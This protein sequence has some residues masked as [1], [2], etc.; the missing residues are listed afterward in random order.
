MDNVQRS[1]ATGAVLGVPTGAISAYDA[2]RNDRNK[3]SNESEQT[4]QNQ[5][6]DIV[7]NTVD[8]GDVDTNDGQSSTTFDEKALETVL[9]DID[10]EGLRDEYFN[11]LR[12]DINDGLITERAKENTAY[13]RLAQSYLNATNQQPSESELSSEQVDKFKAAELRDRMDQWKSDGKATDINDLLGGNPMTFVDEQAKLDFAN[14]AAFSQ[15]QELAKRN[16]IDPL[17]GNAIREWLSDIGNV[18]VTVTPETDE[19]SHPEITQPT[20]VQKGATTQIQLGSQGTQNAD[21]ELIEANEL[22]VNLKP[23]LYQNRDR[24]SADSQM[25][26]N[27]YARNLNPAYL[28]ASVDVT[29]GAPTVDSQYGVF[30][31]NGRL[32]AIQKAYETNPDKAADYKNY[33]IQNATQFGFSQDQ[34]NAMQQPVLVRKVN[35]NIDITKAVEE[36]NFNTGLDKGVLGD[37]TSNAKYITNDLLNDVQINDDGTLN[38]SE[39]NTPFI[40]G[41]VSKIPVEHRPKFFAERK[42][43]NQSAYTLTAQGKELVENA[44]LVKAFSDPNNPDYS[45]NL[46]TD[47]IVSTD[48][49]N[50]RVQKALVSIAGKVIQTKGNSDYDIS[51]DITQAYAL[52]RQ[53]KQE[54]KTA[55][56]VI[57][58][59]DFINPPSKR[60][61]ALTRLFYSPK[62]VKDIQEPL[63]R[64]LE[65]VVNSNLNQ[66]DQNSMFVDELNVSS[67]ELM[68]DAGLRYR[69][70][71][72]GNSAFAKAVDEING[73]KRIPI[74]NGKFI[75]MGTTPDALKMVG[76]TD[77]NIK[78][79]ESVIE[80]VMGEQ[81]GISENKYDHIHNLTA[82]DLKALPKNIN[83]PIA[84]FKS[85]KNSSNPDGF[86]VLT[87]L[88]E[89]KTK[90]G[91]KSPVIA[92]LHIKPTKRGAE[93][94]NITSA[95]GRSDGQLIDAFNND[96]LY[97]D[98]TK[99]QQFL[100]TYSLQLGWDF[101]SDAELS[102]RNIKTESDLSQYQSSQ[103]NQK[104]AETDTEIQQARQILQK[105]LVEYAD[106]VELVRSSALN[107]A[108]GDPKLTAEGYFENGKV[109]ILVDNIQGDNIF[110]RE[111]RLAWVAW[112]ELGHNGVKVRLGYIYKNLMQHARTNAVVS[113]IGRKIQQQYQSDGVTIPQDV[114]TEEAIVEL[115]A[116]AKTGNWDK[117]CV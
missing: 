15:I 39:S 40:Q 117:L 87:E 7:Q 65:S 41:L 4:G 38:L 110:S 108:E 111:E 100:N 71:E 16:G 5:S 44:L 34:V 79:N 26:I 23:N 47:L 2:Y 50:K 48:E 76:V 42:L 80:K 82:D 72:D 22:N 24:T 30:A 85:S 21:Y 56:Q 46:L 97:A 54:G 32:S 8:F 19:Q 13:G 1:S 104:N 9:Q 29:Q 116:A 102:V 107:L 105:V 55:E 31:G 74:R 64:Y 96:L 112:H 78:I 86:V 17:D 81:L 94:V 69:L 52:M 61:Q 106:K 70:N 89:L 57:A 12:S 75:Q 20:T 43:G 60:V 93:V 27:N 45:N 25:Q 115:Y 77:T 92:A 3:L 62:S 28:G 18:E 59:Q 84:I 68:R 113:V 6:D 88:T 99:A 14:N 73:G 10:D 95:Y 53:G 63:N 91:K 58:Q 49:S 33:L 67:D 90:T 103:S 36:G 98:R 101:T 114:A 51:N 37:A 66:T 11:E 35:S 109:V 83:N